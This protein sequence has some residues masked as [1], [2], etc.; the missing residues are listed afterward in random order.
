MEA[1]SLE[2][3]LGSNGDA[4]VEIMRFQGLTEE[5]LNGL[6]ESQ[7]LVEMVQ[8]AGCLMGFEYLQEEY[9]N[10]IIHLASL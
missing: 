1:A 10:G 3:V 8:I 2:A 7:G 4:I 9:A 6:P 5:Q